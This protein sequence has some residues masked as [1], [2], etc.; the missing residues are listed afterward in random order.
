[1]A[2]LMNA[3]KCIYKKSHYQH[4]DCLPVLIFLYTML[5]IMLAYLMLFVALSNAD[6]LYNAFFL[7]H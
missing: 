4:R 7:C 6:I 2:F 1:M 3:L 5:Y